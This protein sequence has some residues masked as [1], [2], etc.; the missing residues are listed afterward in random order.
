MALRSVGCRIRGI[1]PKE[2]E[3][4]LPNTRR[5][6]S[7]QVGDY[8]SHWTY[9]VGDMMIESMVLDCFHD[10]GSSE[11]DKY[12]GVP[13]L[14]VELNQWMESSQEGHTNAVDEENLRQILSRIKS[15]DPERQFVVVFQAAGIMG[16]DIVTPNIPPS[17]MAARMEGSTQ[18]DVIDVKSRPVSE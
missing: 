7:R 18:P 2:E 5:K 4:S 11:A 6:R 1:N 13:S 3:P 14:Y 9:P 12:R 10:I 16:T 17:Q 8:G 15:Y